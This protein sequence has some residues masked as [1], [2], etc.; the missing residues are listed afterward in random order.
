MKCL[1]LTIILSV[2]FCHIS[3]LTLD[4]KTSNN[5][6]KDKITIIGYISHYKPC[7]STWS[8][9]FF[10][11]KN[12]MQFCEYETKYFQFELCKQTCF[13]VA[14]YCLLHMCDWS[15]WSCLQTKNVVQSL[16]LLTAGELYNN[17]N[18]LM[19]NASDLYKLN[20]LKV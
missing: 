15:S 5:V 11:Y 18:Q 3:M 2:F 14:V 17:L 12:K 10:Q 9:F 20:I 1:P 8:G 6:H 19:I 7:C 4:V 13:N 16:H